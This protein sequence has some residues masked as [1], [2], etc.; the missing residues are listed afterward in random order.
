MCINS[1]ADS[2]FL[3]GDS[4]LKANP[5]LNRTFTSEKSLPTLI[6]HSLAFKIQAQQSL[7]GCL[8]RAPSC[9]CWSW[10]CQNSL[11]RQ[12]TCQVASPSVTSLCIW[13]GKGVETYSLLCVETQICTL[14][15]Y[16]AAGSRGQW[17]F[18]K[19]VQPRGKEPS[20]SLPDRL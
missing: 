5:N 8:P 11:G 2:Q 13:I 16:T 19:E 14:C 7:N 17:D 9:P 4:L 18:S 10:G 15:L 6:P 12:A 20:G 1:S 3:D